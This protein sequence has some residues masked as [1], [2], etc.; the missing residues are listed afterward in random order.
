MK[1][2]DI[3]RAGYG[4]QTLGVERSA[5][6]SRVLTD[7]KG[8]IAHVHISWRRPPVPSW[9]TPSQECREAFTQ[10]HRAL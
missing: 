2:H 7:R 4:E 8:F 6:Q 10:F 5:A 3:V 9:P 1:G